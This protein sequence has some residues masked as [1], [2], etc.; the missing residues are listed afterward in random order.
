MQRHKPFIMS[1]DF[2]NETSERFRMGSSS[3]LKAIRR[4]SF[5]SSRRRCWRD[6]SQ[7]KEESRSNAMI[8]KTSKGHC[9]CWPLESDAMMISLPLNAGSEARRMCLLKEF[10]QGKDDLTSRHTPAHSIRVPPFTA[11]RWFVPNTSSTN[12]KTRRVSAPEQPLKRH[13]VTCRAT[14]GADAPTRVHR[15]DVPRFAAR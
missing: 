8:P 7:R 15:P 3:F 13:R 14:D 6:A 9:R 2:R 4:E 5:K 10:T 1:A 11:I 12:S